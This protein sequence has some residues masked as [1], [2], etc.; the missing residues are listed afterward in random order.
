MFELTLYH[1]IKLCVGSINPT[2][3]FYY[4]NATITIEG[5][6]LGA[7][8]HAQE[9]RVGNASCTDVKVDTEHEV[10]TC[11]SPPGAIGIVDVVAWIGGQASAPNAATQFKYNGPITPSP[12]PVPTIVCGDGEFLSHKGQSVYECEACA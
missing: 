6:N 1:P 12:T 7:V 5:S 3:G 2:S 9:I 4:G 8:G 10:L 11:V